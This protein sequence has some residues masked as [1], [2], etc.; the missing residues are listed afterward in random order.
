MKGTAQKKF[1]GKF[2]S[3]F[4]IFLVACVISLPSVFADQSRG[5]SVVAY[6]KASGKNKEILTL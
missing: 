3:V 2:C 5:I 1:L 6:D 4:L